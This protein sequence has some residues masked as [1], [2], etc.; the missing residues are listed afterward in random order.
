MAIVPVTEHGGE[1]HMVTGIMVLQVSMLG[2]GVMVRDTAHG[3]Q[4]EQAVLSC[5]S[6]DCNKL[7]CAVRMNSTQRWEKLDLGESAIL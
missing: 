7:A 2:N 4:G 5:A 6:G 3:S 1:M